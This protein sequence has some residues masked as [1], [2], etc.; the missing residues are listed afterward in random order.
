M[1]D[2]G[3][4]ADEIALSELDPERRR[5]SRGRPLLDALGQQ[6]CADPPAERDERL[7][8]GLLRVVAGDPVGDLAVDLDDRR[9]E[10][11]DEGEARVARAGIVDRE[12]EAEPA[13]RLDL[14][15]IMA[16]R[17][18]TAC[19]SVHSSVIWRGDRPASFTI[20][21]SAFA[22][23]WSSSRLA[24]VKLIAIR[25]GGSP[26]SRRLRFDLA[27]P[28]QDQPDDE[29]VELDRAIRV[30]RG[31][32]DR[33][34]RLREHRHVRPEQALVLV[35]L[36]GR[37]L[38]DRLERDLVDVPQVEEVVERLGLDDLAS[39]GPSRSGRPARTAETASDIAAMWR[40]PSGSEA[41]RS[42]RPYAGEWT[43]AAISLAA[44]V[45]QLGRRPDDD[46]PGLELQDSG[47]F[48]RLREAVRETNVARPQQ[49][50]VFGGPGD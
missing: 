39:T 6:P 4:P 50:L 48:D 25:S 11:G 2:V 23:N 9:V 19:C 1:R 32:D 30:D 27:R 18:T 21:A 20:A 33:A 37:Q 8:E 24:G 38:D 17:R 26:P 40:S 15:F 31:V 34:D 7:D 42:T 13:E 36:A 22:S 3:R 41:S 43:W 16:R 35:E 49:S 28:G 14:R 47:P 45:G 44:G 29:R 46:D 10:G 12:P 5:A